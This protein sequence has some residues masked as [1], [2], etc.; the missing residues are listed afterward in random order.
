MNCFRLRNPSS[1]HSTRIALGQTC[2]KLKVPLVHGA[3]GWY[4]QV[5]TQFPG[6]DI[7]QKIHGTRAG[8]KGAEQEL[9]NP[10][11]T[12][13]VVASLQI[14]EVCKRLLKKGETQ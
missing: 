6:E 8:T 13:A 5:A 3:A 4:G 14:S 10:F 7:L 9:G 2:L 11:F 1:M 12:P